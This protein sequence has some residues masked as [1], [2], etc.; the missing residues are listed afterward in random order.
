MKTH[1]LMGLCVLLTG[2]GGGG[3]GGDGNSEREPPNVP[4]TANAGLDQSVDEQATVTLS[5]S[6]LDS[7]G[8]IA[9]Y[10]W[11]Q[12]SGT[13]VDLQDAASASASFEAPDKVSGMEELV[14][15]LTVTD[16]RGEVASDEVSVTVTYANSPPVADAGP[17]MTVLAQSQVTL[18]GSGEDS[19]GNVVSY[20]WGLSFGPQITLV[21]ADTATASFTA[22]EWSSLTADFT[23]LLTVTDDLGAT[24]SDEVK[25]TINAPPTAEAGPDRVVNEITEVTLMGSGNDP[26]GSIASFAWQQV[27]GPSVALDTPG[28]R[29]TRF[30]SPE[31]G[32]DIQNLSFRFT[33]TDSHGA[34]ASDEVVVTVEKLFPITGQ[35]T[36]DL[37]PMVAQPRAML[38]YGAIEVRPV[39]GARVQLVREDQVIDSAST[40]DKG[41]FSLLASKTAEVRVR[42]RAELFQDERN[43]YARVLDNT[44]DYA[45]YTME[46]DPFMATDASPSQTLHAA[47]GWTGDGYGEARA[48]APFAILDVLFEAMQ[49][50][51]AVDEGVD[52]PQLEAFWSER[53][54][55]A[56]TEDGSA[57]YEK[58]RAGGA[59]YLEG[60]PTYDIPHSIYLVGDEDFD[61]D[62]YDRALIAHEWGH[63][64]ESSFSRC[65][66]LGGAHREGDQ[67]DM[68]TAFSEGFATAL[69][70]AII[71]KP[72]YA[73]TWGPKQGDGWIWD[74]ENPNNRHY[75]PGW[76]NEASVQ[77]SLHDLI[78]PMNDDVL[79]LGFAPVYRVMV[80]HLKNTPSM[81]SI[82]AFAHGLKVRET[83]KVAL[84]DSLF[85][86]HQISP[87]MDDYGSGE[88][89]A[90]HPTS[91]DVLPVYKSLEVNGD[92][93]NV[94]STAEFL[95]Q[96]EYTGNK[97]GVHQ[98]LKLSVETGDYRFSA[99]ATVF[100]AG[101]A[102]RP[103]LCLYRAGRVVEDSASIVT[104]SSP[105]FRNCRRSISGNLT[106]GDYVLEVTDTS[107][108][109]AGEITGRRCFDVEIA[110]Q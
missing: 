69:E 8:S 70:A 75:R 108:H 86:S 65:D 87:V 100:P 89:N 15:R 94:C 20:Q 11:T 82:F 30:T 49:F 24:A 101:G 57:D 98:L 53:N 106:A 60:F 36:F 76:F 17:D 40:D 31:V 96:D 46:G 39:R 6:G 48:A 22:P 29:A 34:T 3:G 66:S 56:L 97:L 64:F 61:T 7:D 102:A 55:S 14:F 50:I 67:L 12:V 83:E 88:E 77:E 68:R 99:T 2:C 4:P 25:I 54:V 58:G 18:M 32:D 51:R 21:D 105:S 79:D 104:G 90:G 80:D 10:A 72:Y 84:I 33:V 93:V 85:S 23:I 27:A 71:D 52:F 44:R 95:G 42:V 13:S 26:D 28:A 91:P 16:N 35:V 92:P 1:A 37:V 109:S 107:N 41:L 103:L 73:D 5:G 59:H 81:V 47:S 45:L 43:W 110:R 78:D 62:E 63:Y 74:I 9:S 38:D 19:D